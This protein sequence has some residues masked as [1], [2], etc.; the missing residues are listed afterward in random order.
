VSLVYA[1]AKQGKAC[2]SYKIQVTVSTDWH[3]SRELSIYLHR[4]VSGREIHEAQ[5]P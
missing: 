5:V 4:V 3:R 2:W 1:F